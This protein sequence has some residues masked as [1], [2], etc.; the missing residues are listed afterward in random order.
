MVVMA[1]YG[2]GAVMRGQGGRRTRAW[3]FP[4]VEVPL[5]FGEGFKLGF[6]H[7]RSHIRDG[8]GEGSHAMNN[9]VVSHESG[10]GEFMVAEIDRV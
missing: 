3:A 6:R 2:A 9:P 10:M 8:I 1:P 7:G 5:E 4:V